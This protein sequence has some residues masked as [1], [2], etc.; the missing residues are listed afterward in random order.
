[1]KAVIR[2][3]SLAVIR[4]AARGSVVKSKE[5]LTDDFLLLC[6]SANEW[7]GGCYGCLSARVSRYRDLASGLSSWDGSWQQGRR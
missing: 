1:M 2:S 4:S 7:T 5:I 6:T 3:K